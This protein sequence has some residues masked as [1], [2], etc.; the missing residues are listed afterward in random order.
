MSSKKKP[1]SLKPQ[2][3]QN[4]KARH[5]YHLEKEFQ[6]GLALE[7]WEVKAIKAGR[8]QLRDSHIICK[9]QEIWLIGAHISPLDTTAQYTN[10]DPSR[11]RKLLLH[12]KEISKLIGQTQQKGFTMVPLNLHFSKGRIKCQMALAKGKKNYDKRQDEQRKDWDRDKARAFK[13]LR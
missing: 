6:A 7:G 5:D 2:T 1:H 10:P 8:V 9:N 12:R 3:I 4:R 13:S 11:S